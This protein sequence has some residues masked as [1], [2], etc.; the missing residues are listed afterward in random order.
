[1]LLLNRYLRVVDRTTMSHRHRAIES[2]H[3]PVNPRY[4]E[5]WFGAVSVADAVTSSFEAALDR[6][7]HHGCRH[8]AV[9]IVMP[10]QWQ[11]CTRAM[12]ALLAAQ[13]HTLLTSAQA[14]GT[15]YGC[16]MYVDTVRRSRKYVQIRQSAFHLKA[17]EKNV[18]DIPTHWNDLEKDYT[19]AEVCADGQF[20]ATSSSE[21]WP[22]PEYVH[23]A[24]IEKMNKARLARTGPFARYY[25]AANR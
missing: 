2:A 24:R 4:V 12:K 9:T 15:K 23:R 1:M 7:V 25:A 19:W 20:Y 6:A 17:F 22:R 8:G 14:L 5:H 21:T 11:D 16:D 3:V 10:A 18:F 13:T